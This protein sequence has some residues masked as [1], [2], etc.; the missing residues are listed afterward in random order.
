MDRL[1][2]RLRE[3]HAV[4]DRAI[5]RTAL[6]EAGPVAQLMTAVEQIDESVGAIFDSDPIEC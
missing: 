2:R 3:I 6:I 1:I 5:T 4:A